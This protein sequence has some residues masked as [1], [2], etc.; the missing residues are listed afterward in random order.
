MSEDEADKEQILVIHEGALTD[1]VRMLAPAKMIRDHHRKARITLLCGEEYEG[2]LKH[3]P[4]FNAVETN[5]DD[6]AK[7]NFFDRLKAARNS[8]F[9]VIYDLC[10]SEGA[11]KIGRAV[12]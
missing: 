10:G 6:T 12:R 1:V 7:R 2:L 3:C 4:Y 9:D 11:K 8:G 5:L